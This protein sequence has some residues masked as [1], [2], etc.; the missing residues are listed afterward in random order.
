MWPLAALR[1]R[2]EVMTFPLGRGMSAT[3]ADAAV[4]EQLAHWQVH[5]FGKAA[6]VE[7]SS[8]ETLGYCGLAKATFARG[9][10]E[11]VEIGWRLLPEHWRQGFASE[12]AGAIV[13]WA[14]DDL[15]VPRVLCFV[16]P[17]NTASLGVARR[18]GF[19][20]IGAMEV[21]GAPGWPVAAHTL[22][23]LRPGDLAADV[24][25]RF[26][27]A[28]EGQAVA[29]GRVLA[30][31]ASDADVLGRD[32]AGHLTGSAL[33]V[34][35]TGQRVLVLWHKKLRKWLQPG[36]HL[37]GDWDL[38]RSALREATEETGIEGLR[39]VGPPVDIDVHRVAPPDAEPHDHHDVRFL[40]VAPPGAQPSANAEADQFRWLTGAEVAGDP[41]VD[42]SLRR[43]VAHGLAAAKAALHPR[44]QPEPHVPPRRAKTF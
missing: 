36:G 6:V 17:R 22:S 7:E 9:M 31:L 34:D 12:A 30:L 14:F 2:P 23:E 1:R 40:L 10:E 26:V 19:R 37:D 27:P 32:P 18:V 38:A 25:E 24:V 16:E 11:D 43:L 44:P 20:Q 42:G 39:L 41:D 29:K 15:R 4:A 5:G 3:E 13:R 33:V 28:D 21:A 8:G 35:A